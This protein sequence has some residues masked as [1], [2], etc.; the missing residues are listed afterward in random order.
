MTTTTSPARGASVPPAGRGL[1]PTGSPA[2]RGLTPSQVATLAWAMNEAVSAREP[3]G[4]CIDCE[5]D[6]SLCPDHR[7]NFDHCEAVRALAAE[8]GIE[9]EDA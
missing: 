3:D 7:D 1:P 6:A 5:A 2:P 4:F 8:L 9:L